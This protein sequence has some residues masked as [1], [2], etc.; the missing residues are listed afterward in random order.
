MIYG[1]INIPVLDRVPGTARRILDI[2]CG[3]GAFGRAVKARQ[4]ATVAGVTFSD[5]EAA[6]AREHLDS[7][8]TRDL[9]SASLVDL[10]QFDC[11]VCSH[12][13]EHLRDPVRVLTSLRD[14]LTKD[15]VVLVALPNVLHYRQRLAFLGGRFRY[16]DGGLMDRTHYR[17]FDWTTAQELIAEAGLTAESAEAVGGWPGSRFAGPL[18][19]SLDRLAVAAS[20][21]LFGVQF[22]VT[23]RAPS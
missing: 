4:P 12:V 16:T 17:F 3:D 8:V 22:V 6:R 15:G 21:G 20:P 10:G 19:A 9:E 18:R 5:E 7:V 14:N 11:V 1:A 23:A 2:G 13:L